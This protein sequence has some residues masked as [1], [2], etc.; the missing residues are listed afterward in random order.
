MGFLSDL[1]ND[2]PYLA[3]RIADELESILYLRDAE[4]PVTITTRTVDSREIAA[5]V[6][7]D[8]KE[9][10]VLRDTTRVPK[11]TEDQMR[12]AFYVIP[13][14]HR[15]LNSWTC[16]E[17]GHSTFTCPTLSPARRIYYAHR[18]YLDQVR[19]NP[20]MASF[21]AQKTQRR[22]D[23]GNER[24]R[25]EKAVRSNDQTMAPAATT[26]P[27]NPSALLANPERSDRTNWPGRNN[28]GLPNDLGR[29]I[30]W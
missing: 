7:V 17:C 22:L 5:S 13:A 20:P 23:L 24:A 4:N 8:L 29:S 30:T 14:D 3:E 26:R 12:K 18:Y 6:G 16:R 9:T 25:D 27:P 2:D 11:L 15:E 1:R 28:G 21:L 10:P 19:T